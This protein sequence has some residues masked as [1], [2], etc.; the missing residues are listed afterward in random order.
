MSINMINIIGLILLSERGLQQ[1]WRPAM[2]EATATLGPH[3]T[4]RADRV[5]I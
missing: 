2:S 4:G 5:I 1:A 3:L